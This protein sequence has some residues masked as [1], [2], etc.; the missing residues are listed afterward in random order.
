MTRRGLALVAVV[1]ASVTA[2][3]GDDE[4]PATTTTAGASTTVPSDAN[5]IPLLVQETDL[6][7]GYTRD[8]DV[9][10]TITAFCA[11]QDAATGLQA[12]GRA[13]AG[14]TRTPAGASVIEIVFRFKADGATRFVQHA[15][16]LFTSCSDVPDVTGLAFTYEP[17]SASVATA[18][19]GVDSS[20]SR[21][22][23]SAGSG[24]L[25]VNVAVLQQGDLGVLIAVLGLEEPRDQLDELAVTAFSAVVARL[26][27]SGSH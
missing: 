5:L 11:G 17:A 10:D 14:F 7:T 20:A 23:V 1:L 13:I 25:T 21:Y 24:N 2:C 18:L 4:P 19:A 8:P 22:G 27:E 9:D 6:P 26:P 3:A 12:S 15:E 16:E